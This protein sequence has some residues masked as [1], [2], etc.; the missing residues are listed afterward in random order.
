MRDFEFTAVN[1]SASSQFLLHC[2]AAKVF[3]TAVLTCETEL[4]NRGRHT[5][6]T[7]TLS[8]VVISSYDIEAT[9]EA[10]LPVDSVSLKF[11]KIEFAYVPAAG[12]NFSCTWD[13]SLAAKK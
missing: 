5:Y 9:P 3:K 6:L 2:A 7:I 10:L 11:T 13:L 8:D 4:P 1:S 12:G